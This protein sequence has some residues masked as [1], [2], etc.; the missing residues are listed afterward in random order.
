M[1]RMKKNVIVSTDPGIDDAVAL[2]LAAFSEE[3]DVQLVCPL[4][5]NVSV[6]NT[7]ANTEKLLT[8]FNKNIKIVAGSQQPL[9]R[10]T[11]EASNVHG[12]TGMEGFNFPYANQ[13]ADTFLTA[14]EAMHQVVSKNKTNTTLV[15]IG[16]L[17]DIA[18]FIH[19]YP[20]DL[21]KVEEIVVMGGTLDRGNFGVLSEFNFASDPE[22]TKMVFNSG[23]KI[24]VAPMQ[25]GR[26]A[27]VMPE[28][29]EKIK[30]LNKTGDMFYQLFSKY[31]G[32]SFA[33][34]L[35][36]YD[37]LAIA[38]IL[39]PEIFEEVTTR[40]EIETNGRLTAGASLI[41]LKNYLK[42]P[43]NADVAV[44]VDSKQ[45]EEWFVAALEKAN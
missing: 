39:K 9:I 7:V 3:L 20:Q 35:N 25:V 31:R 6:Q 38:L 32:G 14:V 18:L 24:R 30:S 41:D 26:Q 36:M 4:F 2:A 13:S 22:A 28:T 1:L 33:S 40:V 34:G 8:F 42:L 5:G 10:E 17:T 45:F 19:L 16:P 27:K 44:A 23:V 43:N 29:S 11:I 15:G 21:A 12:K 37:A